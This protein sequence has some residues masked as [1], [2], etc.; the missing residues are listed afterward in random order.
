[1]RRRRVV[2][3]A[4]D[5]HAIVVTHGGVI[6][7]ELTAG[8]A[9]SLLDVVHARAL[10]LHVFDTLLGERQKGDV[11]LHGGKLSQCT[12]REPLPAWCFIAARRG[13]ARRDKPMSLRRTAWVAF[14]SLASSSAV[15]RS[16]MAVTPAASATVI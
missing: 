13:W 11:G 9:V 16:N 2:R 12:Y 6:G 15:K 5:R 4:V 14:A 10:L 8:S 1:M 3:H 7:D